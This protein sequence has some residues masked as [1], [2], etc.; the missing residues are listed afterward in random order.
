IVAWLVVLEQGEYNGLTLRP[1]GQS[2]I[3]VRRIGKAKP[4]K[5]GWIAEESKGGVTYRKKNPFSVDE[6][7]RKFSD[8]AD[9]GLADLSKYR[10]DR[11]KPGR[12][13]VVIADGSMMYIAL[14]PF[15]P[16]REKYIDL[17]PEQEAWYQ[18]IE[19]AISDFDT[20][21]F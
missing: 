8:V 11:S 1:D 6:A 5:P 20:D 3:S 7:K 9:A 10:G 4:T 19:D 17:T 18:Q 16:E 12:M 2:E 15:P 21:A 14:P 13:M